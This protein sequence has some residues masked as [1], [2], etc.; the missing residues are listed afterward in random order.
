MKAF[1]LNG[2]E[3]EA[4]TQEELDA[5]QK[6]AVEAYAREHGKEA[7]LTAAQTKIAELEAQIA[8][9]GN[10]GQKERL[11][12][13]KEQAETAL[14]EL[15]T[16]MT[17]EISDLK[18]S[19]TSGFKKKALDRV[20]SDA[21][22]R[23]KIEARVASLMKTGE[24]TN[25]EEGIMRAVSDAATLVNGAKPAPGFMD[26]MS[27]AG[28]R[29]NPQTHAQTGPETPAAKEQRKLLGISDEDV[30]KYGGAE[31]PKTN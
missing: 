27:G 16:T 17:K 10:P 14:G 3:I 19:I 5:K 30:A 2:N 26:S 1:D 12:T 11:K 25:D 6:E 23:T 24:Y 13:E 21:E 7:E 29:G 15:R 22:A 8:T 4:F 31:L 18:E 20:T 9:A 28:D